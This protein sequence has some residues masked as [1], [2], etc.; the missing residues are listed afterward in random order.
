[1]HL[2]QRLG[3]IGVRQRTGP[4]RSRRHL[5]DRLQRADL[6]LRVDHRH[7]ARFAV[8][9][10]GEGLRLDDAVGTGRDARD[11]MALALQQST[12][13]LGRGMLDGAGDDSRPVLGQRAADGEVARLG[14]P[15]GEDDFLH[16]RADRP[17]HLFAGLLDRFARLAAERVIGGRVA[18]APSQ[19]GQH[20]VE[21]LGR[22]GRGCVEVEIDVAH[23]GSSTGS[24]PS[25]ETRPRG[26]R[27][28]VILYPRPSGS[29]R[30]DRAHGCACRGCDRNSGPSASSP[31]LP[32]AASSVT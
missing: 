7:Q 20:G 21:H 14:A 22:H 4:F 16:L 32:E 10:V 1:M 13:G 24:G 9:H 28:A 25:R 18:E 29:R 8:G 27:V 11:A 3:S 2:A 17:C 26:P 12:A 31:F 23:L 5:G 6:V 15:A 30:S 19:E